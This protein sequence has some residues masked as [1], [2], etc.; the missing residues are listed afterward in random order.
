VETVCAFSVVQGK[1][2]ET[3]YSLNVALAEEFAGLLCQIV[4]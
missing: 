4:G 1:R 2:I 3:I